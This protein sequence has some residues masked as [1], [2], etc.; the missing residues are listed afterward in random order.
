MYYLTEF[1]KRKYEK[2]QQFYIIS[3]IT[4]MIIGTFLN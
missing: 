3:A 2:Q 4:L 1:K